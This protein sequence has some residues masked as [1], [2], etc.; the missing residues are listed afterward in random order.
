GQTRLSSHV[1]KQILFASP[2]SKSR[3]LRTFSLALRTARND[4]VVRVV[5]KRKSRFLRTF[6]LALRTA[7]NDKVVR[8]VVKRKSRF[9]VHPRHGVA[10]DGSE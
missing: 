9:L 2:K 1:E 5:V 7:R 6:S 4:K 10:A 3:F 8:V